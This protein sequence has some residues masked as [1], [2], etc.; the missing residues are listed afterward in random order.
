MDLGPALTQPPSLT[1]RVDVEGKRFWPRAF[2]YILDLIVLNIVNFSVGAVGGFVLGI[3]LYIAGA[4]LGLEPLFGTSETLIDFVVGLLITL[5]YFIA[6]ETLC[7]ATPG[8]VI[9]RMRV[10][11]LNGDLPRLYDATVRGL[12]RLVDG[13]LF[14]AVAAMSMKPPLQQRYGDRHAKTL[15]LASDSSILRY[16]N[17]IPFFFVAALIYIVWSLFLQVVTM[18]AYTTFHSI[19]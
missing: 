6:F 12:W 11:T 13:F 19:T 2:A 3:V 9:L 15:V 8:K 7:G 1:P 16:K 4:F 17:S 18:F 10:A 5:V 14:G